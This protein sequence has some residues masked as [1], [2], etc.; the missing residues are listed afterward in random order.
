MLLGLCINGK[1]VNGRVNQD[2]NIWNELLG[3]PLLDDETEGDTSGQA[4]VQGINLKY[5]K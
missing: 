3:A 2:N 4:R 5:L 1:E